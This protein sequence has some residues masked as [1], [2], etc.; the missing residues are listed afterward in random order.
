MEF[1]WKIR[2]CEIRSQETCFLWTIFWAKTN[3]PIIPYSQH[4]FTLFLQIKIQSFYLGTIENMQQVGTNQVKA[5]SVEDFQQFPDM[6]IMF[7]LVYRTIFKEN[8]L[9]DDEMT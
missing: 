8:N 7:S 5:V 9:I 4:V 6:W 3:I 2:S 1:L